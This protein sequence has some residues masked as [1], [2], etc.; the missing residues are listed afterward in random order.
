MDNDQDERIV[1]HFAKDN[2]GNR[3]VAQRPNIEMKCISLGPQFTTYQSPVRKETHPRPN[4]SASGHNTEL[5]FT[6]RD[7]GINPSFRFP[8]QAFKPLCKFSASVS[9]FIDPQFSDS[10]FEKNTKHLKLLCQ[11]EH[12]IYCVFCLITY[13]SLTI[14]VANSLICLQ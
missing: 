9:M 8:L 6:L 4:S 13:T 3:T 14:Q 2:K 11:S 7:D 5:Y 12:C 10:A 1:F